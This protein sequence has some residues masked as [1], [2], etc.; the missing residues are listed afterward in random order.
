MAVNSFAKVIKN[1]MWG[2][3]KT[4]YLHMTLHRNPLGFRLIN[5]L[6]I[7]HSKIKL[8]YVYYRIFLSFMIIHVEIKKN[9]L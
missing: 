6:R 2:D 8:K 5:I 4:F 9:L 7:F 1:A 3:V